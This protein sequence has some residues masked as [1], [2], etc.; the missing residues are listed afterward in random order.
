M[1][2]K[3][4]IKGSTLKA[5]QTWK[6][7]NTRLE[8]VLV[9]KHLAHFRLFRD[10]NKRAPVD[11]KAITDIEHYLASGQWRGKAGGYAIQ[12]IAGSFVVKLV[13][14][15]TNVVG[16]PLYETLTLLSGEGFD[17]HAGWADA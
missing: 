14:S 13:G 2:A 15:Y 5:G 1:K 16:L 7:D 12:G 17:V 11:L 10:Q 9:G 8:V 6:M 4:R 3:N